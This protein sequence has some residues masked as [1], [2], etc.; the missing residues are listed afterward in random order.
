[1]RRTCSCSLKCRLLALILAW[2]VTGL[3][4]LLQLVP[5]NASD[6]YQRWGG[7]AH[8]S[9][10][11]QLRNTGSKLCVSKETEQPQQI[12][13]LSAASCGDQNSALV[14]RHNGTFAQVRTGEC[15]E[16]TYERG[17]P[18]TYFVFN[19]CIAELRG[20]TLP[21]ERNQRPGGKRQTPGLLHAG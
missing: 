19:R 18:G 11:G 12:A 13:G 15:L 4:M 2:P 20:P 1:M 10:G 8:G 21:R 16:A 9:E 3:D 6:P 17:V 7:F 14:L 5:C